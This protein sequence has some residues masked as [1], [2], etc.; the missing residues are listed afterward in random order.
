M[1]NLIVVAA[2]LSLV[3][4]GSASPVVNSSFENQKQKA[5]ITFNQPVLLHGVK[6]QGEYLFVHDEEARMRGE[7]CARIYK[8]TYEQASRLVVS[9]HCLRVERPKAAYFSVTSGPSATGMLEV[10]EFQFKG[11]TKAHMVAPSMP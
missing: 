1:R 10:R 2:L 9:F 8:G 7:A 4:L 3:A 11:E 6:L 5:V